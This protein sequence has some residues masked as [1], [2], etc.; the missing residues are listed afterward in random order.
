M[1]GKKWIGKDLEGIIHG[2]MELLSK[3]FPVGNK[4]NHKNP[5]LLFGCVA[6]GTY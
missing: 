5:E 1:I 4:E 6:V 3:Q 2:L